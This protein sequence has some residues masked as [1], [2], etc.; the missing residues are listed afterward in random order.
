[1]LLQREAIRSAM[2]EPDFEKRLFITPLFDPERQIGP[3]SIDLR[4]GSGFIEVRRR[5]AEVIDPFEVGT[6]SRIATQERYDIPIGE[7]FVLHPGQFLLGATLEFIGMPNN[8][9]GQV[10]GTE[11]VK[12]FETLS[13]HKF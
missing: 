9:G 10:V 7:S 12:H 2:D 13:V 11:P 5:D 6:P 4:L 8:L 1:V 3:G